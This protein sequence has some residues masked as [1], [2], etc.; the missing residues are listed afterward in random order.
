MKINVQLSVSG[1]N[2]RLR[3]SFFIFLNGPLQFSLLRKTHSWQVPEI[4][5]QCRYYFLLN[6]AISDS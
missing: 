2:Q 1:P 6:K 4:N 5:Y 3:R